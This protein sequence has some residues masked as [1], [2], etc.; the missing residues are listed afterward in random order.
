MQTIRTKWHHLK[1]LIAADR[2]YLTCR[3]GQ[4]AQH[5]SEFGGSAGSTLSRML[6]AVKD[7]PKFII[8]SELVDLA[9]ASDYELSMLDMKRAGVL[10]FP[11]PA[12]IMEWSRKSETTGRMNH[13]I[14]M[15]RDMHH[16]EPFAWEMEEVANFKYEGSEPGSEKPDFYGF[17]MSIEHDPGSGGEDYLTVSPSLV[18]MSI[19]RGPPHPTS[20]EAKYIDA[21]GVTPGE[22]WVRLSAFGAGLFPWN[23]KLNSHVEQSFQVDGGAIFRAAIGA[24]L[25][26]NTAGVEREVID[27]QRINKK[28]DGTAKPHVPSHTYIHIGRVYRSENDSRG[29]KYDPKRSPRP[30]WRRG[31]TRGVRYGEKRLLIKQM[32]F[33]GRLVAFSG[34]GPLPSSPN[35]TVMK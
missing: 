31:H 25:T 26:M 6:E 9:R 15:L 17:R 3:K 7:L 27:T 32:Y 8:A 22:P 30:H 23:D 28:R 11:Y 24:Y 16:P 19:E 1:S 29:D 34:V 5:W 18:F 33:P 12:L 10:R 2:V 35:Y 4:L 14:V 20:A 13:S 21:K